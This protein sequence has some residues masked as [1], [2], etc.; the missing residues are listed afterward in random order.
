MISTGDLVYI[1][2]A[3]GKAL[4]PGSQHTVYRTIVPT[5]DDFYQSDTGSQHYLT[6]IVEIIEKKADFVIARV[7][8]IYREIKINDRLLPFRPRNSEIPLKSSPLN[9]KAR[10]IVSEEHCQLISEGTIAFIDKGSKDGIEI[11]QQYSVYS[12][13]IQKL[14]TTP[15]KTIRL[16]PV[17]FGTLLV[18]HTEEATATV[19]VTYSK[20]DIHPGD[21]VCSP[22]P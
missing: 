13:D 21:K 16:T 11:G 1:Q 12:Q 4:I 7:M 3:P 15:A 10:V 9:I 18:L 20:K 19:I 6:G 2:P 14:D 8:D 17:N 5:A 22:L